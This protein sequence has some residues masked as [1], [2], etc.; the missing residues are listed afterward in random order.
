MNDRALQHIIA[1]ARDAKHGGFGVL[2]TG[3]KLAAALVLNRPD[4]LAEM[5]YTLAEAR[6][7][8]CAWPM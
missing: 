5:N 1:K 8:S 3:E 6:H 4:W 7:R 2:S